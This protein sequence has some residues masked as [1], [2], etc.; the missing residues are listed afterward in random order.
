MERRSSGGSARIVAAVVVAL[1]V[2]ANGVNAQ[3]YTCLGGC[4]NKCFLR[5]IKSNSERLACYY[6]CLTSCVPRSAADYQYYC[7]IGCSLELCIPASGDGAS[8]ERCYG[9]CSNLCKT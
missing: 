3:V 6:Q 1:V 9:S 5:S 4:Y 2:L 8:L 7:Q